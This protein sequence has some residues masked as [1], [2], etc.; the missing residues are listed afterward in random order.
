[1]TQVGLVETGLYPPSPDA[2][3]QALVIARMS[4]HS[5][6]IPSD[7][8]QHCV[9][10]QVKSS[11]SVHS[12]ASDQRTSHLS[13]DTSH[14]FKHFTMILGT[15]STQSLLRFMTLIIKYYIA[16]SSQLPPSPR[17][18][19]LRGLNLIRLLTQNR[20]ADFHTTLESLPIPAD[21]I[22]TNPYISHPVN[23][24]RWLMEGSYSKVWNAREEAPAEEYRFF[25]D[26]LMGTIRCVSYAWARVVLRSYN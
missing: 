21:S 3:L 2:N 23:L 26:S 11:K 10:R 4:F 14:C 13:T 22:P 6:I 19:P 16:R 17:E 8:A 12:G 18:Y 25:V 5:N 24:E 15:S 20:I 7:L 1:M 9:N